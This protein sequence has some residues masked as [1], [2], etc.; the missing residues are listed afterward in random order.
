M[1]VENV[2]LQ[3]EAD[4]SKLAPAEERL[5][6]LGTIDQKQASI[7]KATNVELNNK[8]TATNK[9]ATGSAAAVKSVQTLSNAVKSSTNVTKLSAAEFKK[10]GVTLEQ[11]VAQEKA[12]STATATNTAETKKA[13]TANVS[14]RQQLRN[15]TQ[16]LAQLKL[17]GQDNTEQYRKMVVEAGHV[18]DAIADA[19]KEIKDAG[20][21]TKGFDNLL[22]SAQ[23]LAGGFA[24]AQGAAAL[25][26][27]E[28]QELQETLLKVN[29]AMAVLQGLQGIQNAL[30]KEGAVTLTV[31]AIQQKIRNAG[32]II[33]NGLQS[34]SVIVR[35]AAT[36]AQY[37]LNTAMSV[38]P[39]GIV[40]VALS[41]LVLL[42]ANF[43]SNARKAA[44]DQAKLNSALASAGDILEGEVTGIQNANKRIVASLQERGAKGSEILAQEQKTEK[45]IYEAR[46][47]ERERLIQVLNETSDSGDKD[48][49]KARQE[50]ADKVLAIDQQLSESRTAF[51]EKDAELRTALTK[52][53]LE[54]QVSLAQASLLRAPK[55]SQAEFA[56]RRELA[57][58]QSKLEIK[59]AGENGAKILEIRATLNKELRQID[60]DAAKVRHDDRMAALESELLDAQEFSKSINER[61]SQSEIDAQKK[62]IQEKA[63]FEIAQEGLTENQKIEI[64]KRAL[65]EIAKLQKDFNK[66]SSRETLEDIISR[67]NKELDQL[68]LSDKERL[69]LKIENIITAAQIELDANEGL[70]D[71]L[72]EIAAKRDAD[73]REARRQVIEAEVEYEISLEAKKE[74]FI[75]RGLQRIVDDTKKN[76][77]DRIEALTILTGKEIA[78]N[79]KRID[80]LNTELEQKL[81][82]QKEY[83]LKYAELVDEQTKITEDAAKKREEINKESFRR[84]L[85]VSLELADRLVGLLS[86]IFSAQSDAE[87]ARIEEQ[88]NRVDELLETG[89]ITAKEADKR[90]KKLEQEEKKA[91]Q[92]QAEREKEIAVFEALLAIPRAFLEGLTQGGPILGAVYAAIAAVQAGLIASRKV[93]KFGKGKKDRYEGPGEVGEVG[94][95]L[96]EKNGRMYVV[97]KPKVLWLNAEDKVYNPSETRKM[98]EGSTMNINKNLII[99]KPT[100]ASLSFDYQKMG[101]AV[102]AN[103]PEYGLMIDENGFTDFIR[104]N[105]SFNKYLDSRRSFK[106]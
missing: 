3:F 31:L 93:P 59:E 41:A 98:L 103:I 51:F 32:I 97:D 58:S 94:T 75:R 12:V 73:I 67:N 38:N 6:N 7:F 2:I 70:S 54:A 63:T 100:G 77:R 76:A 104:H 53:A 85:D 57:R 25:F 89:A 62:I 50:A 91:K 18:K 37:L 90:K 79:Q 71:K 64:R 40:I 81:I 99:E 68:N 14:L 42:L 23:A 46:V 84:T 101:K 49:V 72:K 11:L 65:A 35:G 82:S 87:L 1:P 36:V 43:G 34:E 44:A 92:K 61:T 69:D 9:V 24:V 30:Q 22:G 95:E 21:D 55:N 47:K 96:V 60:L 45:R 88:K 39:I 10:M 15:L 33:E 48:T 28:G 56:A 106:R 26:G 20:S 8:V 4:T 78:E 66:Q 19:G 83:N 13:E 102:A 86:D 80:A 105:N 52:E 16:Q 17:A 5:K 27:A 74:G 29:A